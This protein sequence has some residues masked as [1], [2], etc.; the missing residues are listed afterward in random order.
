MKYLG[1]LILL[2]KCYFGFSQTNWNEYIENPSFELYDT[3]PA[4][5]SNPT[6]FQINTCTGWYIPTISTADYF[7]TCNT[8]T[9][10]VPSN[11]F[12]FQYAY[13]GIAY[14]GLYSNWECGV[15][16]GC[17]YREYIQ[18]KLKKKLNE[19]HL[20]ELNFYI[21]LAGV[22]GGYTVK[23]IGAL[24]S[25]SNLYR[26]DYLALI[27]N[28]QVVSPDFV[29]DTTSWTKVTGVFIANGDEEYLTIGN[30]R[31]TMEIANDTLCTKPGTGWQNGFSAYSYYYI[32]GISFE[33]K[34]EAFL[35]NIFT[36]N[37]DGV[38]DFI[39]FEKFSNLKEF[40]VSIFNRWGTKVF[41]TNDST[42]KWYGKDDKNKILHSGTY[43]YT[44]SFST[45]IKQ[46]SVKGFIQLITNQ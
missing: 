33:D 29:S 45:S 24:F 1:V 20:Y 34:G 35:P 9:V 42:E 25:K 15:A 37:N 26:N 10:G 22:V 5:Y 18:T 44:I 41:S 30:F 31:D 4:T 23:N 43:Y 7:N 21:N 14:C 38:N 8:F 12:G 3:C 19:G 39:D 17:Y 32:D 11:V 40:E 6:S 28:P 27:A 46:Q 13:D 16:P 36:P 2:L